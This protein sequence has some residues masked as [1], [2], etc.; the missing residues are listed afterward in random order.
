MSVKEPKFQKK[1]ATFNFAFSLDNPV[2]K[3]FIIIGNVFAVLVWCTFLYRTVTTQPLNEFSLFAY[4]F[5]LVG[6]LWTFSRVVKLYLVK[7]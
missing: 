1:S 2:W 4:S 7:D 6:S 5:A 3:W